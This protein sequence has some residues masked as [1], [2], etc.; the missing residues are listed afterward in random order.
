MHQ[1]FLHLANLNRLSL[2]NSN[3]KCINFGKLAHSFAS[4]IP[5]ISI[6]SEIKL[7]GVVFLHQFILGYSY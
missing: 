5:S 7:L 2:N 3:S 4:D 1:H 6:V